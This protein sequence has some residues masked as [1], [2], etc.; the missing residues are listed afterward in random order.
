M[1]KL[2]P[3]EQA[4]VDTAC[5]VIAP[6]RASEL[7]RLLNWQNGGCLSVRQRPDI[8]ELTPEEDQAIRAVWDAI[9]DGSSSW[10]TAFYRILNARRT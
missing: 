7:H 2:S 3:K 8:P 10:M 9:P 1:H 5:S 6:A 4:A